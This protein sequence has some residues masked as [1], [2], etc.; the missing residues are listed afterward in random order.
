MTDTA[1]PRISKMF[2][3]VGYDVPKHELYRTPEW[4]TRLLIEH[5][6]LPHRIWEPMAGEDDMAWPLRAAGHHVVTSDIRLIRGPDYA[7]LDFLGL[8]VTRKLVSQIRPDAIVTNPP[9]SRADDIIRRGL[10]ILGERGGTLALLLPFEFDAAV[11]DRAAFFRDNP[12]FRHKIVLGRRITWI[13]YEKTPAGKPARPRQ[14]HA[15]YV[16][17]IHNTDGNSIIYARG[18]HGRRDTEDRQRRAS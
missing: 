4:V 16:W 8:D 18:S 11:R 6:E 15:W 3:G 7:G 10:S 5:V 2:G 12:A 14:V 9:F 13:G 1:A 17:R